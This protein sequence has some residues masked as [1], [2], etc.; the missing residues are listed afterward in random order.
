MSQFH[1]ANPRTLNHQGHEGS[2]R[3]LV[4]GISFVYLRG[5]CGSGFRNLTHY[6]TFQRLPF[7]RILRKIPARDLHTNSTHV[8]HSTPQEP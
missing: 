5:L 3:L 4:S 8:T 6:P 1:D 7:F 2:P